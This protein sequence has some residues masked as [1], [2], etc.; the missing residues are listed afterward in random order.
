M[1]HFYNHLYLKAIAIAFVSIFLFN[2]GLRAQKVPQDQNFDSYFPI[3]YVPLRSISLSADPTLP[4]T[5]EY[6]SPV[7]FASAFYMFYGHLGDVT[8]FRNGIS[9]FFNEG[10]GRDIPGDGAVGIAEYRITFAPKTDLT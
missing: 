5:F 2:T 7:D 1:P 9:F 8:R 10:P 4:L 6:I 3:N